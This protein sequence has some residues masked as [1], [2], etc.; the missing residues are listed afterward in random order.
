VKDLPVPADRFLEIMKS[1][2]ELQTVPSPSELASA[3]EGRPSSDIGLVIDGR[4]YLASPRD[5]PA[6]PMW[7]LDS[8]VGQEWVLKGEAWKE[9]PQVLYEHDTA[10]ALAKVA[11]GY[12]LMVMLRSPSVEKIWELARMDRRMPK[13]STYFW[14]KMWSGFVYYRMA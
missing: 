8:Y 9:E 3:L 4:A 12:R 7:E 13:K 10:K 2:F 5:L 1:R 6:D 11:D 14:P